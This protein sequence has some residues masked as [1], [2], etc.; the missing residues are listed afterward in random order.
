ML[1]ESLAGPLGHP[2]NLG[3]YRGLR[4][5]GFALGPTTIPAVDEDS[6]S[7]AAQGLTVGLDPLASQS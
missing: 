2:I 3:E 5:W 1:E 4:P 6:S 7:L